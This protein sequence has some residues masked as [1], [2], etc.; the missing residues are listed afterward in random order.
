[1]M[2]LTILRIHFWLTIL[3][4]MVQNLQWICQLRTIIIL[5]HRI[6]EDI[7]INKSQLQVA[8]MVMDRAS[9][10]WGKL[11]NLESQRLIQLAEV[12]YQC[13]HRHN[14]S[15]HSRT[16]TTIHHLSKN[17]N[18]KK[19]NQTCRLMVRAMTIIRT[20]TAYSSKRSNL[21]KN[22][23]RM[24]SFQMTQILSIDRVATAHLTLWIIS[25]TLPSKM[26]QTKIAQQSS[27]QVN[28]KA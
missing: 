6:I 15:I 21:N 25:I 28:K 4:T 14:K 20:P 3:T 12:V 9:C 13:D 18:Q 2:M 5:V 16:T 24:W 7:K 11:T 19:F 26:F 10:Q 8:N 17:K 1:M 22:N 23:S 27:H